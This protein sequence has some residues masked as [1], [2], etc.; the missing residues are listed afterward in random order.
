[1]NEYDRLINRKWDSVEL[2]TPSDENAIKGARALWRK[3]TGKAW[4]GKVEI[5]K[6]SNQYTWF[7]RRN[8]NN[9]VVN[10]RRPMP[11]HGHIKEGWPEIVHS[12][13]HMAHYHLRPKE[14][15]HSDHQLNLEAKL[16][17]YALSDKFSKYR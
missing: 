2:D 17:T 3:A 5:V 14:R 15:P 11:I 13:S 8:I 7:S 4:K 1:M 16:T 10:P 12:I 6:R 9:M